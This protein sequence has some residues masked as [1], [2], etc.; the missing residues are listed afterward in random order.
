MKILL[1]I[2][3]VFVKIKL[4]AVVEKKKKNLKMPF[5]PLRFHHIKISCKNIPGKL[6][7]KKCRKQKILSSAE[8]ASR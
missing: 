5:L 3:E 7:I 8:P 6:N 1:T 2:N 4:Y